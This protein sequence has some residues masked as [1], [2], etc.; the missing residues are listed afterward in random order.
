LTANWDFFGQILTLVLGRVT[1]TAKGAGIAMRGLTCRAAVVAGAVVVLLGP[2]AGAASATGGPAGGTPLV[3]GTRAVVGGT[4][5]KAEEVPGIAALNRGGDAKISSV[6]C[7]GPGTCSAGGEYTD[8][9]GHLQAFVVDQVR[10]RW[11]TAQGVPGTAAL[12]QDGY[13][14]IGSLSC[15]WAG[16]CS[17]G[18]SYRDDSGHLQAFVVDRVHGRW[19]TAQ[20]VPGSAALN[21]DGVADVSSVSCSWPGS[22]SAGGGYLDGSHRTQVFVVSEVHGRWGMAQEVRGIAAHNWGGFANVGSVSCSWPGNCSA[23]GSYF[24]SRRFLKIQAF[25]VDQVHGRW[26]K[27]KAIPGLAALNQGEQAGIGSV[28]CTWPGTCSAGGSYADVSGDGQAFVVSEVHGRWGQAEEVP[29]TA[30]NEFNLANVSSV[31]CTGPGTCSA[32]G[33]YFDSADQVQPFVVD[34]VH[35]T[36]GTAQNVPGLAALNRGGL[37][38]LNSVSCTWPGACS[39]GG[40]YTGSSRHEQAFVVSTVPYDP[41]P[42]PATAEQPRARA[43]PRP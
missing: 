21:Q 18:G 4:W 40:Y 31:S 12:N 32:G 27:A 13:A 29:G 19:G 16:N 37:G 38:S 6:S 42:G 23:G 26:G 20:E 7:A 41:R 33:D 39:A 3:S 17:A 34:Q 1:I 43:A 10:G 14:Y 36:W 8:G 11:G 30:P 25:V 5:G 35:G 24:N 9:S 15:T 22:C 2:A 28:S